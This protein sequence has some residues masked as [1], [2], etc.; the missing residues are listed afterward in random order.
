MRQTDKVAAL[1][2]EAVQLV[3]SLLG[4]HDIFVYDE[5]RALSV[6]GT[7]LPDLS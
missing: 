2:V 5:G 4:V 3:A 7:T 1:E 6:V